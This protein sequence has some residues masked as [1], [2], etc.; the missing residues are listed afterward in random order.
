[1]NL[2]HQKKKSKN[3]FKYLMG[4]RE[5]KIRQKLVQWAAW[6]LTSLEWNP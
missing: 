1:M 3:E 5:R 4:R 2:L 6:L